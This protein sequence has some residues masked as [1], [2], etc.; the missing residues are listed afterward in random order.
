[1]NELFVLYSAIYS[2][3]CLW[4][5][6]CI[7]QLQCH[8]P[9]VVLL[10]LLV[11]MHVCFRWG[12]KTN[13]A[14]RNS[15]AYDES[16]N[17]P[18]VC[19]N[20]V[21]LRRFAHTFPSIHSDTVDVAHTK[22]W[23]MRERWIARLCCK[24]CLWEFFDIFTDGTVVL[25]TDNLIFFCRRFDL[26]CFG[27]LSDRITKSQ[28]VYVLMKMSL[29]WFLWHRGLV[30]FENFVRAVCVCFVVTSFC[31]MFTVCLISNLLHCY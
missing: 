24:L 7:A 15:T 23:L 21:V 30:D 13:G 3:T 1:M 20:T 6:S 14:R 18:T 28:N 9:T 10:Y 8:W 26:F 5:A 22:P 4:Y 11:R 2:L 19:V 25:S 17:R 27:T 29:K 12:K 16:P 31:C